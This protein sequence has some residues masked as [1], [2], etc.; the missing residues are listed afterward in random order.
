MKGANACPGLNAAALKQLLQNIERGE[1]SQADKENIRRG[2]SAI[3]ERSG[4]TV[5]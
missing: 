1:T 4:A 5:T 2:H 3:S